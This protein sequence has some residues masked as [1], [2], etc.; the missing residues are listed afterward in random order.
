VLIVLAVALLGGHIRKRK[1]HSE[2]TLQPGQHGGDSSTGELSQELFEGLLESAPDGIIIAD[3]RGNVILV[4]SQTEKMFGYPRGELLGQ[5]IEIF[6]PVRY[7]PPHALHR[8]T[9]YSAPTTRTMGTGLELSARRRDGSEFPVEISLSPLKTEEGILVTAIIRD[10]TERYKA[11]EA[12]RKAHDELELR[13]RE[14]TAALLKATA[15]N[16]H[17]QAQLYRTEK[18]AEIGQLAAG[19]AHEIRNPLAGIRG[20]IEVLREN[21]LPYEVRQQ[22]M[23][24]ILQRVDRL[25]HAVQD[26]L[27][28]AKPM[29]P[30]KVQIQL[31]DLLD[32][33]IEGLMHD[34][35]L[36]KI[37]V[38]K[39]IRCRAVVNTDPMLVERIFINIFLN[40]VQAMENGG[41]LEITLDQQDGQ[42]LIAFTDAGSGIPPEHLD[43]IFNPF[44]TTR[45]KGSG[46]GL[47]LCKKYVEELGGSIRVKSELGKGSTFLVFLPTAEIP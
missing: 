43:S 34:P 7:Q 37:E 17:I 39:H 33:A 11:A 38:V 20:A 46:L 16:E 25:N 32:S 28:Y 27:E 8:E 35:K 2:K 18:L 9:Y 47:A 36:Q 1:I 22:L 6:V 29:S 41:R 21:T 10:V 13:V 19:V 4:N 5:P 42:A 12:L 23:V 30:T 14:R 31:N 26:L 45:A 15:E 3:S 40:A 24:E 44:F